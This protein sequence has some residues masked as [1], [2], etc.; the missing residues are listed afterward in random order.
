MWW[1]QFT[2]EVMAIR[3]ELLLIAGALAAWTLFL[4]S[5]AGMW[6]T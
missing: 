2:K 1:R 5:R 3:G 4:L 6:A